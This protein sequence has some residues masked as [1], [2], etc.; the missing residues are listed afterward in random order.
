MLTMRL[1]VILAMVFIAAGATIA[2]SIQ[3]S[4]IGA[5][6][7]QVV[8]GPLLLVAIVVVRWYEARLARNRKAAEKD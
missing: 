6:G 8:M 1:I 7:W 5:P 3:L 4:K 2:L